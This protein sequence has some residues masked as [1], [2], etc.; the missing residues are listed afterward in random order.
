LIGVPDPAGGNQRTTGRRGF[1]ALAHFPRAAQLLGLALQVAP[2]HI[3]PHAIAIDVIEGVLDGDV[4]AALLERDHHFDL[5]MH[6]GGV[7]GV[8]KGAVGSDRGAVLEKEEGRLLIGV[9]PHLHGMGGVVSAD[10]EDTVDRENFAGA[11]DGQGRDRV[12]GDHEAGGRIGPECT[13]AHF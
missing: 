8:G 13:F 3:E 7:R 10:A 1:E 11:F 2:G 5:V 4:G 6:I 9:V 12:G